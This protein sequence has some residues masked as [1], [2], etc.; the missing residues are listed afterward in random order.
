M[1]KN[2]D[3]THEDNK[4]ERVFLFGNLEKARLQ[5]VSR[6]LSKTKKR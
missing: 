2:V 1:K 5:S 6:S 3:L 4:S